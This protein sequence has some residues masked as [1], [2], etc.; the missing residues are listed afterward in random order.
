MTCTQL[1]H[2]AQEVNWTETEIEKA[3]NEIQDGTEV[4]WNYKFV[5][6]KELVETGKVSYKG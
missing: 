3:L 2:V 5:G 6:L 1:I 4:G